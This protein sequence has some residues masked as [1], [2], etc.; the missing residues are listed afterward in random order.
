MSERYNASASD[1]LGENYKITSVECSDYNP[2]IDGTI[3]VTISVNDVYGDAV[4]GESVTVTASEGNFTQLNGSDITSA[5]SVTG[6]T[7]SSGEFTLTYAC[8]VWGLITFTANNKTTQA[9]V[10]GW[11][12]MQTLASD[13]VKVYTDGKFCKIRI[14]GTFT[15]STSAGEYTLATIN[16]AYQSDA[17]YITSATTTTNYL[18]VYILS[19]SNVVHVYKGSTS[20]SSTGCY[21]ALFYPLKTPLY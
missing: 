4:S 8:S 13:K 5:S 19:D 2:A 11:K 16:S 17:N 6:T 14:G 15:T 3:T 7:N 10:T 20:S 21:C 1:V 9:N 18:P 12:Q